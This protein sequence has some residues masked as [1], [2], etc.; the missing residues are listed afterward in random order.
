MYSTLNRILD[1]LPL[2]GFFTAHSAPAF[3]SCG[4]A[5]FYLALLIA[6]AAALIARRPLHVIALLALTCGI[7]FYAY[8][9]LRK[10][11]T[12]R[13]CLVLLEHVWVAVGCCAATLWMM[14]QPVLPWLD[15]IAPGLC[16]FLAAGR[17]GCLLAGCCHGLPSPIGIV[18]PAAHAAEG[19]P[20]QLVGLRLF[21]VQLVELAS[22]VGIGAV[23]LVLLQIATPGV[24]LAWCSLAYSILRYGLEGI[25]GDPRPHWFGLSQPRWMSLIEATAVLLWM[26]EGSPGTL[27][28]LP[29]PIALAAVTIAFRQAQLRQRLFS[30]SHLRAIAQSIDLDNLRAEPHSFETPLGVKV[31]ASAAGG[32]NPEC[33]HASLSLVPR[34]DLQLLCEIAARAFPRIFVHQT[35]YRRGVLHVYIPLFEAPVPPNDLALVLFGVALRSS[36]EASNADPAVEP[37]PEPPPSVENAVPGQHWQLRA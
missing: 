16:V 34:E 9:L 15:V 28:F 11:I 2:T 33:A 30:E 36:L 4:V 14:G 29:L 12:G 3:R 31:A 22:L 25:R 10:R 21:P 7:S 23:G 35:R 32:W 24:V 20:H 1:E 19:F 13:E 5:G 37:S 8:A 6:I 26:G 17:A 27:R 18:Y